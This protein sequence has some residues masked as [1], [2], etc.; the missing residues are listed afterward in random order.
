ML[1]DLLDEARFLVEDSEGEAAK[2]QR[3]TG[4]QRKAMARGDRTAAAYWAGLAKGFAKTLKGD[5][6][7]YGKGH[8]PEQE[9]SAE[10]KE[11]KSFW[12][13][14]KEAPAAV[15]KF[16]S[17]K[18]YRSEVGGKIAGAFER[19]ATAAWNQV[20][21]EAKEFKTAGKA[22]AK[23]AKREKLTS[24]DKHALKEAAKTLAITAV[25]TIAI[26]GLGHLAIGALAK[27]FA[28]E[29]ALKAVGRAA[30]FAS[31]HMSEEEDAS[32]D[33]WG[34]AVIAGITEGFEKLGSMSEDQIAEILADVDLGVEKS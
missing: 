30:L 9:P 3:V 24:E 26:G 32:F 4:F 28:A 33:K 27:H 6:H 17:D 10:P 20:K 23:V 8:A 11:K 29:T 1:L 16:V 31:I 22:I 19:K 13:R 21:H 18:D 14:I 25:G 15:K 5:P 34:E 7:L 12:Q 2:L